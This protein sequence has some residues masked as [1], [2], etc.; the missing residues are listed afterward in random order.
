MEHFLSRVCLKIKI[1]RICTRTISENLDRIG[2]I[3][4][5]PCF[6]EIMKTLEE[7]LTSNIT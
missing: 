3:A 4:S 6:E 1:H 2:G 7:G 5:S